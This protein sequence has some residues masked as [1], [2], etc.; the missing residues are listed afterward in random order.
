MH[1]LMRCL[2]IHRS[3][4]HGTMLVWFADRIVILPATNLLKLLVFSSISSFYLMPMILPCMNIVVFLLFVDLL[5][6]G[7]FIV[8]FVPFCWI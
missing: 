8:T 1:I 4:I 3:K 2:S 5:K 7:T 6:L